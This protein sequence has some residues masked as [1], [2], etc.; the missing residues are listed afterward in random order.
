MSE[1]VSS[2]RDY[3]FYACIIE[4][5]WR[6]GLRAVK[7]NDEPVFYMNSGNDKVLVVAIERDDPVSFIDCRDG[8]S[9]GE[10][11]CWVEIKRLGRSSFK[12]RR[13]KRGADEEM[14]LIGE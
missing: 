10:M 4:E 5:G 3:A 12:D 8:G 2:L 14:R 11:I 6:L 7:R 9:F 1:F 13:G